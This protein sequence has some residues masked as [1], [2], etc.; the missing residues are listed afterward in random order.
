MATIYRE[1]GIGR[2]VITAAAFVG[3]GYVFVVYVLPRILPNPLEPPP[4]Q[5]KISKTTAYRGDEFDVSVI[6]LKPNTPVM[7]RWISQ[8]N[9]VIFEKQLEIGELY[10][11]RL[12]FTFKER[13]L[14]STM[15]GTYR[16]V[17][18]QSAGGGTILE[19]TITIQIKPI[20]LTVSN[21]TPLVGSTFQLTA[22][23]LIPLK[24]IHYGW[25]YADTGELFYSADIEAG[26]FPDQTFNVRVDETTQPVGYKI[27]MDQRDQGGGYGE[28]PILVTVRF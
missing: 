2:D 10:A 14:D 9:E 12:W 19:K 24:T 20:L 28:V 21:S 3:A 18:D 4:P 26:F 25:K 6:G 11:V 7:F 22:K 8:S 16:I 1:P 5:M 23:N 13:V 17:F 15:T 27:F